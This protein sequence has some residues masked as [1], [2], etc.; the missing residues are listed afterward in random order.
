MVE[1]PEICCVSWQIFGYAFGQTL[2]W[3]Q[4]FGRRLSVKRGKY[5]MDFMVRE[6]P[7]AMIG[8]VVQFRTVGGLF[9]FHWRLNCDWSSLIEGMRG[10]M[11]SQILVFSSSRASILIFDVLQASSVSK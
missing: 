4:R 8:V 5:S 9:G 3:V 2:R 7:R 6:T 10:T 1:L 11:L